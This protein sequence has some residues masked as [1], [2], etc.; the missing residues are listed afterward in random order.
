MLEETFIDCNSK[1][2]LNERMNA[3]CKQFRVKATT[4]LRLADNPTRKSKADEVN[5]F[6]SFFERLFGEPSGNE[7]HGEI[8]PT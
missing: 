1:N 6:N 7:E 2:Y 3:F 5:H 8:N 4:G